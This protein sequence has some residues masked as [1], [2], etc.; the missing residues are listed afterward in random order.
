VRTLQAETLRVYRSR[1]VNPKW[2]EA[3]RRHGYRGGL[4]MAATVDAM[5]GFAATAGVVTDWMFEGIAANFADGPSRAFLEKTNPWALN[6]IVERLVEAQQRRLWS[7]DPL[8]LERL[9]ETLLE[10]E[11]AVEETTEAFHEN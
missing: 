7:A 8:T 11:A 10:S 4:E 2:L 5:F 9:R 6:A 3:M 1:V